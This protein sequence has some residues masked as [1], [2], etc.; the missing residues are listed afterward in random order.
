MEDENP[1][2]LLLLNGD[3][4]PLERSVKYEDVFSF[5]PSLQ[6][7]CSNLETLP[8]AHTTFPTS[9][10]PKEPPLGNIGST[11]VGDVSRYEG[12]CLMTVCRSAKG[13]HP[14]QYGLV[15]G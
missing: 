14:K 5:L 13:G 12:R 6:P 3:G 10:V 15:L 1:K 2:A 11:T 9:K 4:R 7:L 8:R